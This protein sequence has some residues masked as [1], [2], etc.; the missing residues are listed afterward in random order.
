MK[1]L[2]MILYI[3]LYYFLNINKCYDIYILYECMF[4]DQNKFGIFL[5]VADN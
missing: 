3:Y 1:I 2:M 4:I 5:F